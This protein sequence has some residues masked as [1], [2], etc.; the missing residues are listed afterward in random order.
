[1]YVV[2]SYD[3]SSSAGRLPPPRR[4]CHDPA[5]AL[6]IEHKLLLRRV[7][8]GDELRAAGARPTEIEQIYLSSPPDGGSRRV[9]RERDPESGEVT[10][11]YT[12]KLRLRAGVRDEQEDVIDQARFD[13]LLQERDDISAPIRKTRWR[14]PG[15]NG[16]LEID[17]FVDLQLCLVELEVEDEEALATTLDLPAFLEVER[18]VTN[19]PEYTNAALSRR[20]AAGLGAP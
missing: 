10:R 16:M 9:R 3:R 1:V 5:V 17:V 2:V 11:T 14:L 7:P 4:I 20:L 18:D 15:P 13:E 12:R 8:A 19:D 6:E